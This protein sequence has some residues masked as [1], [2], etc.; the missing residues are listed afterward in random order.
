[1]TSI[2]RNQFP[3]PQDR[4]RPVPPLSYCPNGL[5]L[6][7]AMCVEV[8]TSIASR[9]W[10]DLG[11]VPQIANSPTAEARIIVQ[12]HPFNGRIFLAYGDWNET[13]Q[14]GCHVLA[15]NPDTR[16]I[17]DYGRYAT[18]A[19]WTLR[20]VNDEMWAL[21]TD[22][23]VGAD[24][25]A[26]VVGRDGSLREISG[27]TELT[28][29]PW[30]LF[31]VTWFNGKHYLFGADRSQGESKSWGTVWVHELRPDRHSDWYWRPVLQEPAVIRT[32]AGFV[33]NGAMY[34]VHSNGQVDRTTDGTDWIR[35]AAVLPV[36]PVK[37]MVR[38][39]SLVYV[40]SGWPGLYPTGDLLQFDGATASTVGAV[41]DHFLDGSG[42]LWTMA[43][44][45]IAKDGE[46]VT[47]APAGA[48]S[49]C[50]LDEAIYVGS[51]NSHLWRYG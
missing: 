32:Y 9:T 14:R 48:T 10:T 38:Q 34:A 17:E 16:T 49:I 12:L 20:T 47:S 42:S 39:N 36:T 30:H 18:D 5:A 1:M 46:P 22:P 23:E 29:Y 40:R 19:F 6:R 2:S 15:W 27:E 45:T 11:E 7:G 51:S 43:R 44:E 25:D 26:V 21:I 28:P 31:D 35:I 13:R 37:P 24:P 3:A 8:A 4:L 50:V 33:L 41:Q